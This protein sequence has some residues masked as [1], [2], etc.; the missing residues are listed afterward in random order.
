[1]EAFDNRRVTFRPNCEI[2]L[3]RN[4]CFLCRLRVHFTANIAREGDDADRAL[5]MEDASV[6][7]LL[8]EKAVDADNHRMQSGAGRFNK[9]KMSLDLPAKEATQ[10]K[11]QLL[12]C[13]APVDRW[14][15]TRLQSGVDAVMVAA[16][17]ATIGGC[18]WQLHIAQWERQI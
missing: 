17:A 9:V 3:D 15:Q 4:V 18:C 13:C 14:Q 7:L 6:R 2:L 11:R 8:K 16:A 5:V 10:L 1:M 12:F